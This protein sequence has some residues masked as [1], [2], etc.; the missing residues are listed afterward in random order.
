[1]T[2]GL[3]RPALIPLQNVRMDLLELLDPARPSRTTDGSCSRESL[4]YFRHLTY[5]R[6]CAIACGTWQC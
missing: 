4:I 6:L 2:A 5:D 1:M 3:A